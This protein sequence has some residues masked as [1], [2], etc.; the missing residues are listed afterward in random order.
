MTEPKTLA[1]KL[2]AAQTGDEFAGVLNDLF[3]YL[4]KRRDDEEQA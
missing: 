3:G 2:D 4:E 1:E